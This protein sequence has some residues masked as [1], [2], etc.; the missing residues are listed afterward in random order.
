MRK[1]GLF[2]FC[3]IFLAMTWQAQG[4]YTLYQADMSE[5]DSASLAMSDGFL[6]V[7]EEP[8][9]TNLQEIITEIGYPD[10]PKDRFIGMYVLR[11]LVDTMG[12]VQVIQRVSPNNTPL[13][14]VD[15]TFAEVL[16]KLT[17]IPAKMDGKPVAM[18]VSL[19]LRFRPQGQ[20]D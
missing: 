5:L 12:K 15:T 18:W 2:S 14:A 13:T 10:Q 9:P 11:M 20:D 8:R 17:W 6:F 7:D 19:P 1:K 3:L 16:P 4:Q